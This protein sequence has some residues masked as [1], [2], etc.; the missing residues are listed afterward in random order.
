MVD[1]GF[2]C[3]SQ[4]SVLHL[5]QVLRAQSD[6]GGGGPAFRGVK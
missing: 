3:A 2:P 4:N 1:G 6:L 5:G